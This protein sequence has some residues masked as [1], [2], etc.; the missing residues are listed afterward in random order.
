MPIGKR[1]KVLT[2]HFWLNLAV[3]DVFLACL[4]VLSAGR[5]VKPGMSSRP[6]GA[7]AK[8]MEEGKEHKLQGFPKASQ[9]LPGGF[10]VF[11]ILYGYSKGSGNM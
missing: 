6:S 3:E 9:R 10:P 7:C 1:R 11:H 2:F 5:T 4:V 8:K